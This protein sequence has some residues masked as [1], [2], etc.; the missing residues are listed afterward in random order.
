MWWSIITLTTVG[1][2]DVSP[3][4]P[5]GKFVGVATALMGV[6]TVALLT[7]IVASSFANQM[8]RKRALFEAE[9]IKALQDGRISEEEEASLELL[10]QSFNLTRE[11][12]NAIV[13]R[14]K[15]EHGPG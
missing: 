12:A 2:G 10:R 7:G 9:L 4:T 14:V 11:H 15:Q 5:F 13:K 3:I 1:Y 8:A 6:C